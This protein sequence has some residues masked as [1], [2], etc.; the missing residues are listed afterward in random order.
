MST[1]AEKCERFLAL[2]HGDTP[3]LL[4]NAWDRGTAKLFAALGYEAIASTSGDTRRRSDSSTG[5]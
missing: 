2:H 1:H 4:A 5:A 3:L